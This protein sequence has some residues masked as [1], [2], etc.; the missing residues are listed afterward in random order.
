M[1]AIKCSL[2]WLITLTLTL[3]A[4]YKPTVNVEDYPKEHIRKGVAMLKALP[5]LGRECCI[6]EKMGLLFSAS[7][8]SGYTG[9]MQ[10][11]ESE[12]TNYYEVKK[13]GLFIGSNGKAYR[14]YD[15]MHAAWD[16]KTMGKSNK[17]IWRDAKQAIGA[18]GEDAIFSS[19]AKDVTKLAQQTAKYHLKALPAKVRDAWLAQYGGLLY[20]PDGANAYNG[21]RS[22]RRYGTVS[23]KQQLVVHEF[24]SD[25]LFTDSKGEELNVSEVMSELAKTTKVRGALEHATWCASLVGEDDILCLFPKEMK[26]MRKFARDAQKRLAEKTETAVKEV[27]SEEQS[28]SAAR[29]RQIPQTTREAILAEFLELTFMPNGEYPLDSRKWTRQGAHFIGSDGKEYDFW[30]EHDLISG[31]LWSQIIQS[32]K[33]EGKDQAFAPFARDIEAMKAAAQKR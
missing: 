2:I 32:I 26:A 6:A 33:A 15:E 30:H 27:S 16:K 12:H 5:V 13:D 7:G 18:T 11:N 20:M 1:R 31:D 22:Y 8:E 17:D 25:A 23:V 9:N 29:L 10:T 14:F 19:F 24:K 21:E 4:E 28:L 3:R